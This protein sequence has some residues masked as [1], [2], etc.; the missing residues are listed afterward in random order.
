MSLVPTTKQAIAYYAQNPQGHNICSVIDFTAAIMKWDIWKEFQSD[1]CNWQGIQLL[2][3][4]IPIERY[5]SE[6]FTP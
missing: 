2:Y 4:F 3:L 5:N 1:R 6:E